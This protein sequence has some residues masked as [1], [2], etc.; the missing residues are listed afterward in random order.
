MFLTQLIINDREAEK[1]E[2]QE[3]A[4]ICS[5]V[6]QFGKCENIYSCHQRHAFVEADTPVN[7]PVDGLVKFELVCVQNPALFTIKIL[8][9]LPA[10]EG[11]ISCEKKILK[12]E[13]TLSDLQKTMQEISVIQTG[14]KINDICAVFCTKLHEWGRCK[15]L[16]KQ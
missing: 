5:N 3:I 2:D 7:I 15:V 10:G 14:V 9:Y 1:R 12:T 13:D 16:E 6:Y 4:P 8:E 11:W